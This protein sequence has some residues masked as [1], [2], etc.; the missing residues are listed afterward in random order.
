MSRAIGRPKAAAH[1]IAEEIKQHV[2]K[3][4][5]VEA[6]FFHQLEAMNDAASAAAAADFRATQFHG[7]DAIADETDIADFDLFTGLFLS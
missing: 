4:P 3:I 5:F 2:I 7:V 1:H 6:E